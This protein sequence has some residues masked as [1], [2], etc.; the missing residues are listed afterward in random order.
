M[1]NNAKWISHPV[2]M[3]FECPVFKKN[4]SL[5]KPVKRA[6]LDITARG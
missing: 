5:S 4:F 6:T 1:L 2:D 3:G